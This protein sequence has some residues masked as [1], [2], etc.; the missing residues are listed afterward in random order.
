MANEFY[1]WRSSHFFASTDN[2]SKGLQLRFQW[3]R[4]RICIDGEEHLRRQERVGDSV[5]MN[6]ADKLGQNE[7]LKYVE[8]L[9]V[10]DRESMAKQSPIQ[11]EEW[12]TY[13]SDDLFQNES[14]SAP[15]SGLMLVTYLVGGF[16]T[17]A[18][19]L[20]NQRKVRVYCGFGKAGRSARCKECGGSRFCRFLVADPEPV[21]LSMHE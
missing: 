13:Q 16:L 19:L 6:S 3:W 14:A 17:N 12:Q 20:C 11:V 15:L 2:V 9:S 10:S 18:E 21:R 4:G 5:C 1:L 8:R 7:A